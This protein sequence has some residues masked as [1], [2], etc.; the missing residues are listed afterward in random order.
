MGGRDGEGRVTGLSIHC[1]GGWG[2]GFVGWGWVGGGVGGGWWV[3]GL[4]LGLT[5]HA[6][7]VLG[8]GVRIVG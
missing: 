1:E 2:G 5:P 4:G 8:E 3:R 6:F 7:C